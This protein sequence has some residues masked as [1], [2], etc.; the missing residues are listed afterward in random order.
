M[1]LWPSFHNGVAAG[2]KISPRSRNIQSTWILYNKPKVSQL[3][4]YQK[5]SLACIFS[6]FE[7]VFKLLFSDYSLCRMGLTLCQNMLDS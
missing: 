4:F 1:N 5:S 6:V 2:L 7:V 3:P